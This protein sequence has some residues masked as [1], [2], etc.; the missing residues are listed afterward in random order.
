MRRCLVTPSRESLLIDSGNAGAGAA[1]DAA[2]IVA[3]AKDAGLTQ[4]D[5]LITTHWHGDHFGGMSRA[6]GPHS[7]QTFHRSRRERAAGRRRR[8]VPDSPCIRR[9][10]RRATAHGRQ[11]GRQ[12]PRCRRQRARRD[13][14]WRHDQ[15]A[16]ARRR[17]GQPV[18]R[19]LQAGRE[20]RRGSDVGR[21]A[22]HVRALPDD[23]PGRPD[24][25]QGV[26][27]DVPGEPHRH[28][29]RVSRAAPR[30]RHVELRT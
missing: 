6:R 24:E 10:T 19:E 23:A 13:V 9:C 11:T 30:R 5:H 21:R 22:R 18:L 1:R 15:D 3:A 17:R 28:D 7:D 16:A 29:R 12:D 26:R 2:R 20:Q 25:E 4:I 8:R 14:G 27:A